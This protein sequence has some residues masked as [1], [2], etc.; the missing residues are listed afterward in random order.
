MRKCL[1]MFLFSRP[2]PARIN[3]FLIRASGETF[4]YKHIGR[5]KEHPPEFWAVDHNR[6]LIGQGP[7]DWEKAKEAIRT[8]KMFDLGWVELWQPDTPIQTGITVAVLVDQL[9]FYSLNAARIVYTVDEPARFGFAY[10]TLQSH[11]ESGEE[12]FTI[13]RDP[14]TEEVWYDLFAFSRPNSLLVKIAYSYARRLQ[15]RFAADSMAAM[16]R[17]VAHP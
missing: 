5:T 10:G 11:V 12:R 1:L 14:E 7:C 3:E 16:H 8:W 6:V 17:T 15:K 4:S 2:G 13:E 9:G